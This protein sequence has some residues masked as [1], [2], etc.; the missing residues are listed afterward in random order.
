MTAANFTRALELVLAHEGGYADHPKDPGGATNLGITHATLTRW[1]GRPVSKAEVRALTRSEA[2]DIYR[3]Q[4]WDAVRGDALP[5]GL[6][7]AVFD[8]AVNSGPARA[9]KVLQRLV[10]VTVDGRIGPQTLA[11]LEGRDAGR[12]IRE[13][14]AAR[15]SFLARLDAFAVFG[16]GW[17]ARVDGTERAALALAGPAASSQVRDMQDTKHVLASRSV[18]GALVA[19]VAQ[20][21][22]VADPGLVMAMPDADGGNAVVQLIGLIGTLIALWGRFTATK[23]LG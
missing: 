22:A 9:A 3:K 14:S 23:R 1:R 15:R 10:A 21:A 8:Y 19:L 20:L 2:G 17:M 11:A 5:S 4:Y 7:L 12:L 16:R 18:W 13:L 6:D